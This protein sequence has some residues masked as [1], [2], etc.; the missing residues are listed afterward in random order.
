LDECLLL[1]DIKAMD[2]E[3]FGAALE[4]RLVMLLILFKAKAACSA[5]V[6]NRGLILEKIDALHQV[7]PRDTEIH[8]IVGHDTMVR[9]LDRKYYGDRDQAL[10]LLFSKTRFLVANRGA[11]DKKALLALFAHEE[12]RPFA[13]R[14]VPLTLPSALA[15]VSSSEARRKLAQ[16]KSARGLVSPRLAEFC[17]KQGFYGRQA[18]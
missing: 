12:N 9:I 14:V 8:F 1:L 15:A 16:G 7:Y 17:R 10:R 4:E 13:A 2:K 11:D 5:G 18:G 3:V 6:C